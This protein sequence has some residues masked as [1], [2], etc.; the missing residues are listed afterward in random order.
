MTGNLE[1]QA[2]MV[3]YEAL[4][5]ES[6]DREA[7]LNEAC[8]G[9]AALRGRVGA[10][11]A[12][13][14]ADES[15][16][17]VG[18]D[19]PMDLEGPG[20][21]IGPYRLLERIGEGGFGVV[22]AAEQKDPVRRRVALKIIKLGM[23][24]K[25][26]VARFEAERQALA[27]MDH[28]N[29]AKV[30]DAGATRT[31]RPYFVMEL[32]RGIPIIEHCDRAQLSVR[33]RL[34]LFV[35][36][37]N[38]IQHAHQK[39]IVHRDIKP[40][41][42]LI[43]LHD[44]VPVPRIIDFGIAKATQQE[45]TEMTVYTQLNQFIGTPAYMSPEQAEMSG[46]D[47]D[48]RSDIYSLGV[49]L[50]ELL[51]GRTPFE[52][53][54]LLQSGIDQMR[55]IIREQDPP[56]PSTRFSTLQIEEQSTTALRH[57]TDSPRLI[58]LL[59]GDLDW[60]VMKCLQKDRTRRYETASELAADLVRH[61]DHQ[62]IIARPPSKMYRLQ[63]AWR[64]HS[65]VIT[66]GLAVGICLV[67]ALI[68][69]SWSLVRERQ[70][71]A[72]ERVQ[73]ETAEAY[74][75]SARR[76]LYAADMSLAYAAIKANN[77]GRADALLARH[78]PT[79]GEEN[80]RH[81]EWRYLWQQVQGDELY[82]LAAFDHHV[83]NVDHSP[84]GR[85]LAIGLFDGHILIWDMTQNEQIATLESESGGV[86]ACR[87]SPDG[88]TLVGINH[89]GEGI[90]RWDTRSY[91]EQAPLRFPD[92]AKGGLQNL[93]WS[94][95]GRFVAGYAGW[96]E[97]GADT[98][99]ATIITWEV[100]SDKVLW[101][102]PAGW[103]WNQKGVVCFSADSGKL[104]VGTRD[105]NIERYDSRTGDLETAW[106]GHP[107]SGLTALV[108]SADGRFLASGSGFRSGEIKLWD[109]NSGQL[110]ATLSGH[111][112]WISWLEFSRDGDTLYSASCD[113]TV[114][115]WDLNEFRCLSVLRGHRD[116]L[117]CLSLSPDG[118]RLVTGS[119][120]GTVYVWR[121]QPKPRPKQFV[122]RPLPWGQWPA[123]WTFSYAPNGEHLFVLSDAN[124][125]LELDPISLEDRGIVHEF[126]TA[127]NL[128]FSSDSQ[129]V[130]IGEYKLGT[131]VYDVATREKE[132]FLEG[133]IPTH[134]LAQTD[135]LVSWRYATQETVTWD[136]HEWTIV[137]TQPFPNCFKT[138][139][140]ITSDGRL[141][142]LAPYF[143]REVSILGNDDI[144]MLKPITEFRAHR[145]GLS[146]MAFSPDDR[147]LATSSWAGSAR[148]WDREN[149]QRLVTLRGHTQGTSWVAFSP[150][151]QRIITASS[152]KDTIKLWDAAN[153]QE[154]LTLSADIT[155]PEQV[156]LVGNGRTLVARGRNETGRVL[157]AW[158]APTWEQIE[159]VEADRN[160]RNTFA[161][162]LP[163]RSVT[164]AAAP[165]DI[166]VSA[167]D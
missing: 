96:N 139:R 131:E 74:A 149:W 39:G 4:E 41:N 82:A 144:A 161:P 112:G 2:E 50:Y 78:I 166:A 146:W 116:E 23:D 141:V 134:Y 119:K 26:V 77:Y 86:A 123:H 162:T 47:I 137:A 20:S 11:L 159:A 87:Y 92:P 154:V 6:A 125:V 135:H 9:N 95:D 130:F 51:T 99:Q 29:I 81:W 114:R 14:D 73:R 16:H 10:L 155:T 90:R 104:F 67:L 164:Q 66:A 120:D 12:A 88:K 35:K 32:V 72:G 124:E 13:Y 55:K 24:T 121:T 101:T 129:R 53:K 145:M 63:K 69:S 37:C 163:S 142:A 105:C 157:C 94:P 62:P 100:D 85:H 133:V 117:S 18:A 136:T 30:L 45:L 122:S 76:N 71:R 156:A 115:I 158:Q 127:F 93:A 8:G 91:I 109:P 3:F 54:D 27:L 107:G 132:K 19:G 84:D 22:W 57:A 31:G 165:S 1:K 34:E 89:I 33:D 58:S 17:E 60:I 36:L 42:I 64:R 102:Q 151:G 61:R 118:S 25:E 70:A 83:S 7:Y 147:I 108:A 167:H 160:A 106:S 46:L 152:G 52:E 59:R 68:V 128:V 15:L 38:A 138:H 148:L 98:S 21:V 153:H 28:P 79:E 126:G 75:K 49:L 97:K 103:G 65:L 48:T 43:T 140:A 150:D 110:I 113:Q 40:S 5:R 80:L 143:R 44:S 56:K 111:T